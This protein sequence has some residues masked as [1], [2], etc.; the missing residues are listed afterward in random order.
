VGATDQL[1][2]MEFLRSGAFV[3][4]LRASRQAYQ[5]RR[6]ALLACLPRAT[7]VSGQ[8]AGLHCVLWLPPGVAEDDFC[9]RAAAVGL[10]LQPLG[11][12]CTHVRLPAAVILGYTALTLA[13]IRY[14]GRVLAQLLIAA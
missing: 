11:R 4:H 7:V 12:F 14:H 6:D 5:T 2:L 3:R 8:Q 1:G 13:Q 10:T 9:A